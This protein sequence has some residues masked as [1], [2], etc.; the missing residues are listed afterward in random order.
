M[1][2]TMFAAGLRVSEVCR[3]RFGDIE[4]SR[5]RIHVSPSK[6]RKERYVEMPQECLGSITRYCM[7]LPAET[8]R[9]LTADSWLFPKQRSLD[10]PIYTN[11][12]ADHI[13]DIED[14]IGWDHR[15][16]SHTFRRAYAT[17]NFLDGNMTMEEIQAALGHDNVSTTRLY[18][19][20]G[21]SSL[22][23]RRHSNSITG[24]RL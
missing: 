16:T 12:V 1:C 20:Q 10:S 19:R 4:K 18:V 5:G 15:F 17:H 6:R 24:M 2:V 11:Y 21:V 22:Q 8:R 14:S 3:L 13:R 7:T 23:T 9:S